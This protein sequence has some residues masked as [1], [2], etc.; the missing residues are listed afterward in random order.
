MGLAVDCKFQTAQ[1]LKLDHSEQR[2]CTLSQVR[3]RDGELCCPGPLCEC[4]GLDLSKLPLSTHD[5][6]QIGP[7]C[8]QLA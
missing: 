1:A 6:L 7:G 2:N 3:D 8:M 5:L 4:P